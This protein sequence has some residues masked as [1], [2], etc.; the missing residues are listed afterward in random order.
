VTE[1][2]LL[3]RSRDR[4]GAV[5]LPCRVTPVNQQALHDALNPDIHRCLTVAAPFREF[6]QCRAW[7]RQSPDWPPSP[8][9]RHCNIAPPSVS[10]GRDTFGEDSFYNS[11]P[12]AGA[13]IFNC[14]IKCSS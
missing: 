4:Q 6:T 1:P 7:E 5:D 10:P 2:R 3:L 8:L 9:Q 11:R 14:D 12:T 13:M